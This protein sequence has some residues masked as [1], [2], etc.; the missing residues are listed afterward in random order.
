MTTLITGA[1]GGI[2]REL[3]LLCAQH[4]DDL[5]I[6]GRD[7]DKLAVLKTTLEHD[8]DAHVVAVTIDLAHPGAAQRLHRFARE[9]GIVVDTLINDAGFGDWSAFLDMDEE[10]MR[11]MMQVNMVALAE[12]MRLFGAD[13]RARG[14][15]R[16]LNIASVAATTPG[17]YMAMYYATKAFVRSL[18]EAV[19]YE[20]RSTGVTVTTV[21]P[22]PVT[23]GFEAAAHMKG[24]NFYTLPLFKPSAPERTAAF[25]Y[26]KMQAGSTLAYQGALAKMTSFGVR[27]VPRVLAAALAAKLNGGDPACQ[28]DDDRR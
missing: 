23:T 28:T 17:P 27:L 25:A 21:C 10:R 1:T 12:L 5:V 18:G 22:G 4:D 2:G 13:M 6:T 19:S 11:A 20:L 14:H 16:I 7:A 24:K 3:A 8:L 15:G 9:R 26:A